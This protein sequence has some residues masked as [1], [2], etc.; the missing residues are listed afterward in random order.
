MD[1]RGHEGEPGPPELVG[2][3]EPEPA[4]AR[5]IRDRRK[6]RTDRLREVFDAFDGTL[7]KT[8]RDPA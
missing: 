4:W 8:P 6:A 5:D 7:S 3:D 2:V 1:D